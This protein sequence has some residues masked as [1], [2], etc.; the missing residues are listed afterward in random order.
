VNVIFNRRHH[1]REGLRGTMFVPLVHPPGHAQ[2]DFGEAIGIIGGVERKIPG[3]LT[4]PTHVPARIPLQSAR[5]DR[6][7]IPPAADAQESRRATPRWARSTRFLWT[8]M[9][10]TVI[11]APP[12]AVSPFVF[13]SS[14][15][16]RKPAAPCPAGARWFPPSSTLRVSPST[17]RDLRRTARTLMSRLGVEHDIA[18]L[19]IGHQRTGLDRLP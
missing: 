18:E 7:P 2:A 1:D 17:P 10:R 14:S 13:P 6:H 15:L 3:C 9:M 8:E 12:A 19:A 4:Q 5:K 16:R 11:A